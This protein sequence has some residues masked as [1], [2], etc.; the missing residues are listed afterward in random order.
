MKYR[1]PSYVKGFRCI[2][3]KCKD[4]CCIG[5]EISVDENTLQKYK[6]AEGK[7]FSDIRRSLTAQ[8]TIRLCDNGRCPHLLENGL[9]R[10]ILEAGEDMLCE[11]CREH[12]R[13]YNTVGALCEWGLSLAC[14]SAAQRILA[15]RLPLSFFQKIT[16]EKEA[17]C[18]EALLS[19]LLRERERM[20]AYI[21]EKPN[22]IEGLLSV[23]EKW[24]CK[25]QKH[26]DFA[27]I[28]KELF[29]FDPYA[30]EKSVYFTRERFEKEKELLLSLEPLSS[31][32][33][34]RWRQIRMPS[35]LFT[36]DEYFARLLTYFI[37]RYMLGAAED[38]DLAGR[39]GLCL[40]AALW[41]FLLC[42]SEGRREL[43]SFAE[44]AKDFSKELEC[45]E[46]NMDTV[47][48][49]FSAFS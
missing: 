42:E 5:W 35:V 3:D 1:A 37:Y 39:M 29:I 23:L 16:E 15:K 32:F 21:C 11:I 25:L 12:P 47:T 10:I 18:D 28:G 2:A 44:A 6:T 8:G 14:E 45:S 31:D 48:D 33:P 19:L 7:L 13:F 24:S 46:E 20:L 27:D 36:E 43:F 4:S 26:M 22:D 9:C 17:L 34:E 49:A 38:G 30:E 41:C 40:F